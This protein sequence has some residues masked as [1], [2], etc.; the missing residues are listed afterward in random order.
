MHYV[1]FVCTELGISAGV[2]DPS[3]VSD[4][5]LIYYFPLPF[6]VKICLYKVYTIPICF[7]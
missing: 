2:R 5:P 3:Q 7:G 6:H 1:V 4:L